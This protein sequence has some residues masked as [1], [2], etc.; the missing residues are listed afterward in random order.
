MIMITAI[1]NGGEPPKDLDGWRDARWGMSK[2]DVLKAFKGEV[3][4]TG[5]KLDKKGRILSSPFV[6]IPE[7]MVDNVRVKAS[8]I[9]GDHGTGGLKSVQLSPVFDTNNF[10]VEMALCP[11]MRDSFYNALHPLLV[12]KYGKPTFEN[13]LETVGDMWN[14]PHTT[15]KFEIGWCLVVFAPASTD[16][17]KL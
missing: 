17:N 9:F 4:E 3:V 8:F 11:I 10:A 15:V 12:E 5:P 14:F 6:G 7:F 13:H 16:S 1:L 2:A